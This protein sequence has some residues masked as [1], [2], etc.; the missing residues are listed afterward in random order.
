MIN[1]VKTIF[2]IKDLEN[3]S[4]VKAHTIRIWEKRYGVFVPMRTDTNIRYYDVENLQKLLNITLLHKHGYKI[5]KIATFEEQRIPVLVKQIMSRKSASSH[6][7]NAFKLAMMNFDQTQFFA[8]YDSILVDKSFTEIFNE[9]FIPLL[10]EIGMLWQTSTI[11]PA[12]EHFISY[13]IRQKILTNTEKIQA[14][15]PTKS[16]KVFILFLPTGEIHDLGLMYSNYEIVRH[17][18]RSV[19]L[20]ENVP[21]ESF[22]DLHKHFE[23]IVYVS[24]LTVSLSLPERQLYMDEF[25]EKILNTKAELWL[26]G[27]NS[28]QFEFDKN[29]RVF[30]S[31]ADLMHEL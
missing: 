12:H 2:S 6:A 30:K 27:R 22:V 20:G 23:N 5:S 4:G 25:K 21:V 26:M 8:T 3:L 10:E 31:L 14:A 17:G 16:D 9:V 28:D 29:I 7:V 1:N 11:T 19:Y 13:L 24:Y 18:Y 15:A